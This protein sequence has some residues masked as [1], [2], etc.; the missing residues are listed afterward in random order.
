[1]LTPVFVVSRPP[2]DENDDF[3]DSTEGSPNWN[4]TFKN[5]YIWKEKYLDYYKKKKVTH[6]SLKKCN[7]N[8]LVGTNTGIRVMYKNKVMYNRNDF[9]I[10]AL[11]SCE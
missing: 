10:P 11:L 9:E 8:V 3:G 7:N 6:N 5:I 2:Y 4:S 1:M